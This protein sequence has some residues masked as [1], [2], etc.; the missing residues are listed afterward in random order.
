MVKP[1]LIIAA[2]VIA[3][4]PQKMSTEPQVPPAPAPVVSLLHS[5]E[6]VRL[7][8]PKIAL[9]SRVVDVGTNAKGEM[10]VPKGDTDVGWYSRGTA[11]GQTGSAVFAAHVYAAF[12]GLHKLAPG[13]DIYIVTKSGDTEHFVVTDADIRPLADVSADELF[14]KSGGHYLHLITCAGAV[15]SDR[16]TYTHRLVVYATL[17]S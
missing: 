11:P 3:A 7:V 9:K 13:D 10:D 14:N 4:L 17:V 1:V 6:P 15:T 2:I 16:S 8:I 5:P 12:S